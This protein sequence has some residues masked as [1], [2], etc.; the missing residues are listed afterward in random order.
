MTSILEQSAVETQPVAETPEPVLAA[1][2]AEYDSPQSVTAAA[3]QVR[4]AGYTLTDA[5]TPFPFHELDHALGIGKT[6][7]PWFTLGAAAVGAASGLAMQ[8]W[9]NA[10]DYQFII[11]GK[12]IFSIPSGMPVV[13]A[14]AVLF[15]SFATLFGMLFL[16]GL[17]RLSNP[18]FGSERFLRVTN[19]RFFLSIDARDPQFRHEDVTRFLQGTGAIGVEDCWKPTDTKLPSQIGPLL[20]IVLAILCIP[21]VIIARMRA[22]DSAL[23]RFH[24]IQDMDFQP[25]FLPQSQNAL[26]ADGRAMRPQVSG[27]VARGHLD[28]D[29][30]LY[31]GLEDNGMTLQAALLGAQAPAAPDDQQPDAAANAG[32]PPKDPLDQLP[33]VSQ[34]P[35][36]IDMATM[37]RGQER[38]NIYCATCHGLAGDGDG[39]VTQRA[40]ELEQGTWVKPVSFHT[41][42]VRDQPV[43]RL[44][45]SITHGVRK[46]PPMGDIIPVHDRWAILLYLRA[47]QRSRT[48]S[49]DDVPAELLP[50]LKD[51]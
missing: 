5:Y 48:G 46:M 14:C 28:A 17:P 37:K 19:D 29:S 38:Y 1:V 25:K 11:S 50:Q 44:F 6:R 26:F 32:A 36:V 12:P 34:F 43:G 45:H 18:V 51:L 8:W 20:V 13:F 30:R 23:P 7:L 9:M 33:W 47:L 31:R 4:E 22:T 49:P 15:A 42:A 27:T 3:R 2:L 41:P 40:L 10:I 35:V 21:P 16:N 39:L 24:L